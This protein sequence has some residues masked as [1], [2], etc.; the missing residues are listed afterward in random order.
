[1]FW[2][3]RAVH[4]VVPQQIVRRFDEQE[5]QYAFDD[6]LLE[7]PPAIVQCRLRRRPLTVI[8]RRRQG[9]GDNCLTI[10]ICRNVRKVHLNTNNR[11]LPFVS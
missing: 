3:N 10:A 7:Y 8:L 1:M 4:L 11:D 2:G 6:D 9:C 5:L